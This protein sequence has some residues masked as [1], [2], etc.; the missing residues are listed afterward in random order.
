[1][2]DLF[3]GL[4]LI[5]ERYIYGMQMQNDYDQVKGFGTGLYHFRKQGVSGTV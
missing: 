4:D 3:K 5:E 2:L 1:V